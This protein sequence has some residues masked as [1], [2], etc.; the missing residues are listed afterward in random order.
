[1]DRE[2][3]MDKEVSTDREVSD[4]ISEEQATDESATKHFEDQCAMQVSKS[5]SSA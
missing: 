2:A 4:N 5:G 3:S 1:M